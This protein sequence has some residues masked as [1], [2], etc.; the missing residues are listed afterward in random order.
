MT[1][2]PRADAKVA[3]IATTDFHSAL[4]RAPDLLATL[5]RVRP[6]SLIVDSG[7]FFE[8]PY[9]PVPRVAVEGRILTELYDVIAPGNHG[10]SHY[11]GY[12][13]H[14][15]DLTVCANVVDPST[16]TSFFRPLHL[17][18]I[19]GRTVAVTAVIRPNAFASI[20]PDLRAGQRVTDPALALHQLYE[21]APPG[22]RRLGPA[23]SPGLSTRP[24]PGGPL[25]VP[26]P[27]LL[28]PLPQ[29]RY[30]ARRCRHHQAVEGFGVQARRCHRT[31]PRGG[32][33]HR[34]RDPQEDERRCGRQRLHRQT[35]NRA[36]GESGAG[37]NAPRTPRPARVGL[38]EYGR[39]PAFRGHG[40]SRNQRLSPLPD[41]V[42]TD[43]RTRIADGRWPPG[44]LLTYA[45]IQQLHGV[46]RETV[47]AA[48]TRLR[49]AGLVETRRMGTRPKV[50]GKS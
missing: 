37:R 26:R 30:R 23:Q 18:E 45:D 13:G 17:A 1:P 9:Y 29:R 50:A 39:P 4:H 25:P 12:T 40:M 28:R 22:R 11:T 8:G 36:C 41:R 27:R 20:A 14:L 7:D 49:D 16:G 6:T 33:E 44:R 19:S 43:L 31:P 48:L 42:V 38:A 21:P 10:W 15:R 5:H 34:D 47:A 46:S 35:A 24:G 32:P 3:I 2:P